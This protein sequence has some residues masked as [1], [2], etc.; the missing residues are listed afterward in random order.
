MVAAVRRVWAAAAVGLVL[1]MTGCGPHARIPEGDELYREGEQ[2][3]LA[4]ATTM[5]G[6]LMR[7]HE[8]EWTV[9]TGGYGAIPIGCTLGAG[10]DFG[11]RFSY[12]REVTLPGLD[13]RAVSAAATEAFREAG[14]S[15][16]PS[17]FGE[18]E[19]AEWNLVAE[20]DEHGRIVLTIAAGASRVEVAAD[21]PCAPGSAAELSS[22]V[23][24]D[25]TRGADALT[26]RSLPA[27]EGPDSVPIFSFPAGSPE[28]FSEDGTPVDPQPVV[29]DP[30]TAPY[31]G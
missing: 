11:Y 22:M 3:Y 13:R 31:G 1:V 5:H 10:G 18:G 12:R 24:A 27:F 28:Y 30:P 29:T 2:R 6:I 21:T 20:D 26:W 23:T 19:A 4:M 25:D 7:V 17:E 14:L 16:E 8:G 15:A 9:P